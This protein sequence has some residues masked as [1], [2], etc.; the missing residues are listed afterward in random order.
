[1]ERAVQTMAGLVGLPRALTMATETP[2]R[3]ASLDTFAARGVGGRADLVALDAASGA[4]VA[5]WLAGG[6]VR[7]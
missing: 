4:V 5:V 2:G 1:M 6:R 7:G 3:V